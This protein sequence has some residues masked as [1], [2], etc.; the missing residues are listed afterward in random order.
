MLKSIR[1]NALRVSTG[2]T[3]LLLAIFVNFFFFRPVDQP[4]CRGDAA[5]ESSHHY[6]CKHPETRWALTSDDPVALYTFFLAILT[7]G[8]VGA[9]LFQL[10]F[11]IAADKRASVAAGLAEKQFGIL[12]LQTDHIEK[13]KEIQRLDFFAEHRSKIV[14]KNVFFSMPGSFL[15]VTYELFNSGGSGARIIDGFFGIDYVDD[16]RDFI[17]GGNRAQRLF[18][19]DISV[20]VALPH[21]R[22]IAVSEML[23]ASLEATNARSAST[24]PIYFYGRVVYIDER[25]EEFSPKRMAVFRRRFTSDHMG[26]ER[27]ENPDHEYSD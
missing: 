13:Q 20:G 4:Q 8:L 17:F 15:E 12:A 18:G 14:L 25:G 26:F 27:T 11:L 19:E 3:V 7:S 6:Q 24:Y 5:Y 21:L 2:I 9:S 23:A 10:P 1:R 22:A 16:E